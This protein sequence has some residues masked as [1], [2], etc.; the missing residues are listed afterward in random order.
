MPVNTK[1]ESTTRHSL[2]ISLTMQTDHPLDFF[3]QWHLTEKCN[4]HCLHCYQEKG[5]FEELTFPEIKETLNEISQMLE[6]WSNDYVLAFQTSI[7][8]TGGEPFLRPDLFLILEEMVQQGYDLYLLS[9]GTLL[10]R[11]TAR[12]LSRLPVQGVQISLEGLEETHDA[13]R[14]KGSFSGAVKGIGHLVEAGIPVTI[15][16]T[17]SE[18]NREQFLGMVPLAQSLGA[19]RLGFS[20]LIPAGQGALLSSELLRPGQVRELYQEIQALTPAGLE[21][22]SG[23]PL[24]RQLEA[25][26]DQ[27][28]RG[29][30]P[31]GGCAAGVSGLTLMADGTVTP[32]RRL[33]IPLGNVR[34]D[35][36]RELW[37]SSPI[38][39][40]LRDKDSYQGK[41]GRCRR[42]AAC[43]GCRAMAY[44][45]SRTGDRT[46]LTGE[47]PQC[48]L[49]P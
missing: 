1:I 41:C 10:D 29:S 42:W 5:R 27:E 39:E 4:L 6:D 13:L 23:D 37:S 18:I 36:L 12:R 26:V 38:L 17:L 3:F 46:R 32:C 8:V 49:E 45:V 7:N 35:S 25:G 43:R 40:K 11:D 21:L 47:D 19:Q 14:G 28:D 2:L 30:T 15:N 24:Y 9:N 44:A 22:I 16:T 33:P 34:R 20:R 31:L 48:F